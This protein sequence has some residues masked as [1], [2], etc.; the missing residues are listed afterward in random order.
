MRRKQWRFADAAPDSFITAFPDLPRPVAQTLYNRGYQDPAAARAFL[1]GVEPDQNP[2]NLRGMQEAVRRLRDAIRKG[3]PIVVYGD[4][5]VDGV[6]ATALLV[7]MLHALGA[8]V[9]P[10]IPDRFEEGY[11]VNAQAL[12]KLAEGGARVVVTVDCGIRSHAETALARK[13]G[14][15][16]IVTDHHEPAEPMPGAAVAIICPRQARCTYPT[17]SLAGVGLA[18]KLAQALYLVDQSTPTGKRRGALA[19]DDLLDLVV[20]GTVADM[21]PLVLENRS[22]VRRGMHTLNVTKRPGLRALFRAARMEMG[23]ISVDQLSYVVAPRLNAAGRLEHAMTSY[24]LLMT[25]QS[26]RAEALAAKLEDQNRRRQTLTDEALAA[27][28]PIALAQLPDSRLIFVADHS[29]KSGVVGLVANR[30]MEEF[31]RPAVVVEM[32]PEESRGSGRS[33][34]EINIVELLDKCKDLLV[35]HGGHRAAAGFTVRNDRLP[36]LEMRLRELVDAL[37]PTTPAPTLSIDA[38]LPLT[39]VSEPVWTAFERLAPFGQQ[40]SSPLLAT[41]G[42]TVCDARLV[43]VNHLKLIV[44][45]QSGNT[46]EAIAFRRGEWLPNLP[47]VVDIAYHLELNRWNGS[48]Q[49]QLNIKDIRPSGESESLLSDE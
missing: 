47:P 7:H 37:L 45:D 44:A 14:L 12:E 46:R 33:I 11:G 35:R 18:Y 32:G 8:T 38:V 31:Y 36:Q 48:V 49:A 29:Y 23:R 41:L 39:D 22:L 15:D 2:F 30:L 9:R 40:N 19:P 26:D 10:Y 24:S 17:K 42:A 34:S 20:L 28:R 3:E 43:G 13:L 25:P 6:T 16:V 1:D 21:A 27:A 5:D 4:Y